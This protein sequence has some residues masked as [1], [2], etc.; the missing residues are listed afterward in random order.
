MVR[1]AAGSG[2][3]CSGEELRSG[4]AV[5]VAGTGAYGRAEC[6]G[7]E[8]PVRKKPRVRADGRGSCDRLFRFFALFPDT[9]EQGFSAGNGLPH[10][11]ECSAR[12]HGSSYPGG[13]SPKLE[14]SCAFP[15]RTVKSRVP[16]FPCRRTFP[17][18]FAGAGPHDRCFH[19][20]I[21]PLTRLCTFLS[22]RRDRRRWFLHSSSAWSRHYRSNPV[23]ALIFFEWLSLRRPPRRILFFGRKRRRP[24]SLRYD[25]PESPGV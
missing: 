19:G 5:C 13:Y 23:P 24:A 9:P 21:C 25:E 15:R 20:R 10:C 6:R 2:T 16:S 3:R 12:N 14:I 7:M 8:Q 4:E 17:D 1:H 18:R 11:G 22:E